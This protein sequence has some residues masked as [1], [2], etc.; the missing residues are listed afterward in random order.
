M[1]VDSVFFFCREF[2]ILLKR[3]YNHWVYD[4]HWGRVVPNAYVWSVVFR[5]TSG[6]LLAI[7]TG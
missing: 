6:K 3:N 5:F 4:L 7:Q 2:G 1:Y